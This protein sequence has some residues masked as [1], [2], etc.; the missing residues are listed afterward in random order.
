MVV[1]G[2]AASPTKQLLA[3]K[4]ISPDWPTGRLSNQNSDCGN[5]EPF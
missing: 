1:I 5:I 2:T 4:A 3:R